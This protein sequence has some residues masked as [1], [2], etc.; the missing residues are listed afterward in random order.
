[1]A[2]EPEGARRASRLLKSTSVVSSMTLLSRVSGLARDITFSHWFGAGI[3]M[4]AFIVAFKIPN[5]LRRFF[6]EGAFSQAFVP[7]IAEYRATRSSEEVRELIDRVS[8]ALGLV[9]FVITAI[10][11]VAAPLL[12]VAFA[13]GWVGDGG[14]YELATEMLRFTFPYL[15]FISLTGLAGGI[16][17]TYGRF[18]VPAFTP[19]LLNLVLIVFA[20]CVSPLSGRASRLHTAFSQP[21]SFSFYFKCR[22]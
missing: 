12:I 22:S 20:A 21:V 3:V 5:L 1:M 13:P 15:F 19:V 14:G 4:D 11:V 7:V 8:G 9:L 2:S 16:L 17:N 18:A 6:A 10:G